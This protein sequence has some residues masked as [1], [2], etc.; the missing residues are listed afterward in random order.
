M[1]SVVVGVVQRR[2][3]IY[4]TS[5]SSLLGLFFKINLQL[6]FVSYLQV[7]LMRLR[8]CDSAKMSLCV[9]MWLDS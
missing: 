6:T 5:T 2:C 1:L 7:F 4:W 9:V 3:I 8:V